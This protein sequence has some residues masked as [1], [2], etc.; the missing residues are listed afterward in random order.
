MGRAITTLVPWELRR[1]HS[2]RARP[3]LHHPHRTRRGRPRHRPRRRG[4]RDRRLPRPQRGR[5]DHH[6]AHADHAAAPDGR[7]RHRGRL[8]PARA[9]RSACA[10]GSATSPRAA[11]ACRRPAPAR[12]S[13]TRPGSTASATADAVA[14]GRDLFARLD[15][16]GPVGA[17]RAGRCPAASGAGSTS[18]S[19]S[20]TRRRSCSSTSRPPGSTR[21]RARTCG[22]TCA[23][24]A[25][26]GVDGLPHHALPRR[27]RRALRPDPRHGPR[28][29]RRRR[30]RRTSSSGR[31][32]GDAVTLTLKDVGRAGGRRD[33]RRPRCPAPTSPRST[34]R[35]SSST[36]PTAARRCPACCATS[37]PR[38]SSWPASRSGGRRWTTSS[39]PSPAG[40]CATSPPPEPSPGSRAPPTG[41][42]HDVR[43]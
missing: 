12:R 7:R 35:S 1:D 17:A 25:A 5:Q 30:A 28:A 10:A 14:R 4:R 21:S 29:D 23:R 27:G 18:R 11:P 43:P 9:T 32:P 26:S 19:A 38:A 37:T 24:C 2:P 36:C 6:A 40:R 8:R 3:H 42:A 41:V 20:C 16:D 15:L 33:A 13:S 34:G 39:S 31:C 22:S